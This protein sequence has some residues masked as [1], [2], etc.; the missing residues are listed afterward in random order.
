MMSRAQPLAVDYS[1]WQNLMP[2]PPVATSFQSGWNS[3]QLAHFRHPSTD[4]TEI[5]SSQHVVLIPLG[6]QAVDFDFVAEGRSQTVSYDAKD[7]ESGFIEI[8][9]ADLP[10]SLH[11]HPTVKS[12]ELIQC[13]L[14]PTFLAQVAHESVN[15]DRV[16]L[17]LT[18]KKVDSLICQL[19]LALKS[20]LEVDGVGDRC[21]ADFL[22]TALAAHLLRHYSTQNHCLK[23]YEDGLSKQ[24]L[25]QAIAY[26]DAHLSED[27]SLNDIASELGISQYY[28]CHL[29]KRSTGLSPH[30]FLIQQRLE[31]AKRLLKQP[32]R[33]I[34]AIALDCGFA[35]QSHF[36]RYFRQHTGVNPN[37]FRKS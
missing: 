9:P 20:N 7:Y 29:F 28:F 6:H 10:I 3:I 8:Y 12:M 30:Q 33:T 1:D 15:L 11:S 4:F 31:R 22:A 18:L 35:N 36:A 14:E 17:V 21:Y 5:S 37:Q 2:N 27:I 19:G 32:D 24:K 13:Y 23:K 26:I 25:K 34:T 16:E